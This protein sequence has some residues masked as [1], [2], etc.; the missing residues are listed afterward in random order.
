MVA[1]LNDPKVDNLNQS[2]RRA[3]KKGTH[4]ATYTYDDNISNMCELQYLVV[5]ARE[6]ISA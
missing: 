2:R 6:I 1:I 4:K 3:N 5:V